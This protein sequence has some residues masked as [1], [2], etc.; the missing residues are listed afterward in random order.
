MKKAILSI[1]SQV[2]ILCHR[3][4]RHLAQLRPINPELQ[5]L[6]GKSLK[7]S[8][9]R[10]CKTR[11]SKK[12]AK[13]GSFS[14]QSRGMRPRHSEPKNK[15]RRNT[16]KNRKRGPNGGARSSTASSPETRTA[17][18]TQEISERMRGT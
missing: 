18:S 17:S 2:F 1:T 15:R 4:E 5:R 16:Q 10:F 9:E 14:K 3:T 8:S 6:K 7:K 12:S 13:K 11:K